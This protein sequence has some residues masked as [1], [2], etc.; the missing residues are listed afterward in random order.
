M[1]WVVLE[2]PDFAAERNRLNAEVSDKPDEVIL[3]LERI[4]PLLGRPMVDTLKGSKYPN[5]KEIRI[6]V[7]GAWR[8][9]FAFDPGRNA[10]IP[11]GG[12]KE[13]KAKRKF[14]DALIR[15]A[16]WRFSE[17]LKIEE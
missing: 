17:W 12:D 14:Y 16:D 9:A 13:G 15:T 3:A 1:P 6:A 5:M 2:H 7:D 8:F 10:V 11:C 4:G